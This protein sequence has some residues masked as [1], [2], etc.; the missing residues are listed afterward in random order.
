MKTLQISIDSARTQMHAKA[1]ARL[2]RAV[3]LMRLGDFVDEYGAD[4]QAAVERAAVTANRAREGEWE[5]EKLQRKRKDVNGEEDEKAVR[6]KGKNARTEPTQ[7][8]STGEG[9]TAATSTSTALRRAKSKTVAPANARR[10][11]PSKVPVPSPTRSTSTVRPPSASS[12]SPRL[13]GQ[14]GSMSTAA[15]LITRTP[16]NNK[17]R[18][19]RTGEQVQW[20][21][22]NG[23]PIIG[24]VG[25]DGTIHAMPKTAG[26]SPSKAKQRNWEPIDEDDEDEHDAAETSAHL[27][28][29]ANGL[30]VRQL[31]VPIAQSSAAESPASQGSMHTAPGTRRQTMDLESE[32]GGDVF[33]EARSLPDDDTSS[34]PDEEAY[35]A[36]ILREEAMR[37][38]RTLAGGAAARSSGSAHAATG[39]SSGSGNNTSFGL[40]G[41]TAA[42]NSQSTIRPSGRKAA[43]N[44]VTAGQLG[45]SSPMVR[46]KAV[47]GHERDWR[48]GSSSSSSGATTSTSS[49][50]PQKGRVSIVFGS[51]SQQRITRL[52]IEDL[53]RL[54]SHERTQ[55]LEIL[56][57]LRRTQLASSDS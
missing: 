42:R 14:G 15:P 6:G 57:K 41:H 12:F 13:G 22:L 53:M 32:D 39:R 27:L 35:T 31:T 36:Q 40:G 8:A 47:G 29:L 1:I 9:R 17:P 20:T 48:Q 5:E 16:A 52:G 45:S 55:M 19:A 4:V 33:E 2:P 54:P 7:N 10:A 34:L 50:S 30:D 18:T 23:S 11:Q 37:R 3:R 56:E 38:E 46:S 49:S 21:S 28:E 43:S 25:P 44:G 26:Q 51:G 24:V